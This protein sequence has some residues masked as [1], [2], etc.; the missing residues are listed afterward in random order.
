MSENREQAKI[1]KLDLDQFSF[2]PP[3]PM[4]WSFAE[5]EKML[6]NLGH[7][8]LNEKSV[9]ENLQVLEQKELIELGADM[10]NP[11]TETVQTDTAENIVHQQNTIESTEA[12]EAAV[13]LAENGEKVKDKNEFSTTPDLIEEETDSN[14]EEEQI[15][16][17]IKDNVV[18]HDD[19][20]EDD[21]DDKVEGD[22]DDKKETDLPD[23]GPKIKIIVP[24]TES[25]APWLSSLIKR[26][27]N[28]KKR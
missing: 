5:Y 7:V 24:K 20:E 12:K 6:E 28:R 1:P 26:K 11:S 8:V 17:N 23:H 22:V 3:G 4:G 27:R 14:S 16:H 15:D 18:D 21:D 2:S 19:K 13:E 9:K 10:K 25:T